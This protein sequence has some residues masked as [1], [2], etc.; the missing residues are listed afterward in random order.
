MKFRKIHSGI[1]A[2]MLVGGMGMASS[3][4]WSA[5]DINV[6]YFSTGGGGA[7][8]YPSISADGRYVTYRDQSNASIFI[9]DAQTGER[10][11]ANLT[12]SGSVP[13]NPACD[14]PAMSA[15]SRFVVFGCTAAAMG[16]KPAYGTDAYFVYN[17]TNNTTEMLQ[18]PDGKTATRT[19]SVAISAD[20][21]YVAFRAVGTTSN[22]SLYIR[23]MVNKTTV[24]SNPQS[25]Y[26]GSNPS[27][28]TISDD[29]RYVSFAGR[30]VLS[31]SLEDVSVYDSVT[32]VTEVINVSSAGVHG[33]KGASLPV[34]SGDG[35]VVAFFTGDTALVTPKATFSN[36]GIFVRDRRAGTTEFVSTLASNA[37]LYASISRNGRYVA[38]V[39]NAERNLY[40]YDRL[41]KLSRPIPGAYS[42]EHAPMSTSFSADG[43]YL[44]F[45]S[46]GV[47]SPYPD[48]IAIADLG[49]APGVVLSA[50]ALTLTE[51]G[52]AGTYTLALT[53]APDADVK[54]T[55]GTSAQ[56]SLA[57]NE[58]TFTSTN[59]ST[60]QTVSVQAVADGITE[61]THSANIVHTI[62]TTDTNYSVVKPADVVVSISDGIVPTIVTPGT[63]WSKTEMPLSGTA[64]PGSTVLLTASNRSTGWLSSVSTVA[65]AQGNWS[66]TLSGYTDGVIDLDAQAEGLKSAVR[67]VTVTL[68]VTPPAPTYIDVTGYIRTTGLSMAYN[69]STGKF[70]GNFLLTNTGSISL[71]G[72]LQLQF[73]NMTAGVTLDNATGYHNGAPYITLP[74]GLEPDSSVTVPLV[75]DNPAKAGMNYDVKIY[76][77]TF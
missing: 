8:L 35:N 16:G 7:F 13:V 60:P 59:W 73:D 72:P 64:A 69:R 46:R 41:T 27:T 25:V 55:L 53:Q 12:L 38:Y 76:S 18:V 21:R 31:S 9:L 57:R 61:G 68:T 5:P 3:V 65:D 70:V 30:P 63:G 22:F 6:R 34:M 40:V 51:G 48:S 26:I 1:V 14:S 37:A 33:T 11:Q 50:S 56:L 71:S 49:V 36:S 29:G 67:T 75:F 74:Q 17:R 43:R 45:Q 19:N 20:G 47:S 32:G 62:T 58:L 10:T 4:A 24:M 15:D 52:I 77:G 28:L 54:I 2:A 42:S 44:V 23:D 39:A 66:Y